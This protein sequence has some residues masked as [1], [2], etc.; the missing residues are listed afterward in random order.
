VTN[1]LQALVETLQKETTSYR[2]LPRLAEEQKGI[3]VSGDLKGLQENVKKQEK[4]MFALGPLADARLRAIEVLSKRCGL[5]AAAV[6]DLVKHLPQEEGEP[7]RVAA[8]GLMDVVGDLD[9]LNKVNGKLLENAQAY[10][11]FTVEAMQGKA[12]ILPGNP[13]HV[14]VERNSGTGNINQVV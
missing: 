12:T 13:A 2:E 6:V 8:R 4:V 3:L 9:A 11:K 10:A 5:R 7:L 1:D 14:Q